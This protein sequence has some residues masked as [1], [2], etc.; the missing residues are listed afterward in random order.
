VRAAHEDKDRDLEWLSIEWPQGQ[1]KPV[2]FWLSTLPEPTSFKELVRHAKGRWRI[3]R[4]Y[5]ELKSELGLHHYE[6]RGWR[7]FHHHATL[8]I[9]AYGFLMLERL[10]SKKR[11]TSTTRTCHTRILPTPRCRGDRCSVTYRGQSQP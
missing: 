4:D 11:P 5:E 8:C 7:G 1:D 3:E 9:A 6:G 10:G 2:H